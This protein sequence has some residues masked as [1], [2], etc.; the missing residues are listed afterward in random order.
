MDGVPESEE[1]YQSPSIAQALCLL[2]Q[3]WG[4]IPSLLTADMLITVDSQL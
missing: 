1:R 4:W 3:L 2:Q